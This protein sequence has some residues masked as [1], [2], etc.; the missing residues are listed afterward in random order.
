MQRNIAY[1]IIY[2][3]I[4]D[5]SYS[6]L[7][8]RK[9]LEKLPNIQRAF[10]TNLVNSVLKNYDFLL[11]QHEHLYKTTGLRNKII[12]SMATYEKLF[13]HEKDYVV[14]NEYVNLAKSEF[15]KKFINAIIYKIEE[16]RKPDDKYI[17]YSIPKW[18]YDL[19][20]KQYSEE[21]LDTIL[22]N[23]HRIPL[24]YY[25][26]NH[27][28]ATYDDLAHLNITII[29]EDIFTSD[30]S[31]L[32]AKEFSDGLFYVQDINANSL[33]KEFSLNENDLF[34]DAC[35]APGSKLFNALDYVKTDNAYAND[36]NESRVKL[37]ENKATV[38]GFSGVHYMCYDASTLSKNIDVA[39]DKILID[40]PCS[41]LGVI[42]RRSD[43]KFHIKPESLDELQILQKDILNDVSKLLKQGGELLYSTCTLNR[44]ENDKQIQFFLKEHNDFVLIK[45]R[46][47]IN[48]CGDM[49]YFALLKRI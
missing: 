14:N 18:L 10:V 19:L 5:G 20:D 15:D 2:K 37:I 9:E 31:L 17:K 25:R 12:L 23:Y 7:L 28:K 36:V 41:G 44:K 43:I 35:S 33:V 8:M 48:L 47:I 27:H 24:V 49:F 40:A 29:N 42:G 3:T 16:L 46:T 22:N 38:L 21:E 13:L 6:N 39:F 1:N 32:N 26:L 45:D 11:Y 4:S 30:K 34:L